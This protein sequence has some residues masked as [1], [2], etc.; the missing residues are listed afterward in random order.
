MNLMGAGVNFLDQPAEAAIQ[1]T[2]EFWQIQAAAPVRNALLPDGDKNL[3]TPDGAQNKAG[4][5][6]S[7]TS[8]GAQDVRVG[9]FPSVRLRSPRRNAGGR[10]ITER[11]NRLGLAGG[12]ASISASHRL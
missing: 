12:R 8:S 7:P 2:N 1:G 10:E 6:K 11:W 4:L 9:S 3:D 5:R